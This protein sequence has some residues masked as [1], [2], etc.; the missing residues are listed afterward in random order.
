LQTYWLPPQF[1]ASYGHLRID[2][3]RFF[4]QGQQSYI[5]IIKSGLPVSFCISATAAIFKS[6]FNFYCIFQQSSIIVLGI[7]KHLEIPL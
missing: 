6:L 2:H 3:S 5:T 1:L 4:K 7:S